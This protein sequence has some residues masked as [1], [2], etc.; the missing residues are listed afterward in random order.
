MKNT[1]EFPKKLQNYTF[2][3]RYAST[4]LTG[5]YSLAYYKDENGTECIVKRWTGSYKNLS[6]KWL[7]N[8]A[9]I[10]A[11]INKQQS[12]GKVQV[13]KLLQVIHDDNAVYMILE[14]IKGDNLRARNINEKI[15]TLSQVLDYLSLLG[16]TKSIQQDSHISH[17]NA[18]YWIALL[19]IITCISIYKFPKL[20][21]QVL[22]NFWRVMTSAY[23][24]LSRAQK[25]L[26]HR[27]LNDYNVL[28]LNKHA[29]IIDFE[30]ACIAD[31]LI[32]YALIFLKYY[33]DQKFIQE[34]KNDRNIKKYLANN[35]TAKVLQSY[36]IIFAIYDLCFTDASY[37]ES[38]TFL[39][40]SSKQG[41]SL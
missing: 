13:P 35:T 34:F 15:Q 19:P 5:P 22:I 25:T 31:P 2:I 38:M 30:I 33:R 32:D 41:Y 37:E 1:I 27:D 23:A 26:V 40:E 28:L 21:K 24:L 6:Y 9:Y 17:R 16:N 20:L 14:Y 4:D 3:G 39:N 29:Y 18:I 7:V 10:Y 8:E 36:M 12:P 11:Q